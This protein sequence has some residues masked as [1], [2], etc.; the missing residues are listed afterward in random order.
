MDNHRSS[1]D[2]GARAIT[3]RISTSELA[4]R[5]KAQ[6]GLD[7]DRFFS[8][9][10][11]VL[12]RIAPHSYLR[13]TPALPGD[14]QF[15]SLLMRRMGY[16]AAAKAEFQQAS[17]EVRQ[18]HKILDVGCGTG[19]FSIV[20]N[21]Q[22]SGID[23]NPSAIEEGIEL[24][25]NVR[26]GFVQ[27]EPSNAYDV[28]TVFQVLEH[29]DDPSSFMRA[30][31]QCVKPGGSI[32]VSTPNMNGIMGWVPNDLLNY[33]P[34]H[35]TWWSASSLQSLLEN[36]GCELIRVWEQPLQRTHFQAAFTA[37][38]WPRDERHFTS[39]HLFPVVSTGMRALAHFA[40]KKWDQIPFIKGHTVMIVARKLSDTS[41][42]TASSP[43]K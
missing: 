23:T 42:R 33:P 15:Y 13:F 20:C 5:W 22:Y 3:G 1:T 25:R 10:E 4:G 30:C 24:G 9:S 12:E 36:L 21:G 11:I 7:V 18:G 8:A 6:F 14:S 27:N 34:H 37:L 17:V 38:A 16:E 19:N 40:A 32:I 2:F 29:V 26:L 28:V 31:V 41:L 35:L 43:G 39:S